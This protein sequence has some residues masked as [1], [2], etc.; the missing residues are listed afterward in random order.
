MGGDGGQHTCHIQSQTLEIARSDQVAPEG[1]MLVPSDRCPPARP[2]ARRITWS[3]RL[4]LA[5]Q[6]PGSGPPVAAVVPSVLAPVAT[7]IAPINAPVMAPHG[8]EQTGSISSISEQSHPSCS[9]RCGLAIR[10]HCR[11]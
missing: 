6:Q 2:F 7:V 1:P 10:L 8:A 3:S 9:S 5:P 4:G 11:E